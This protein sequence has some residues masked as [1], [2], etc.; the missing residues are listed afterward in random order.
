MHKLY[1]AG[2][3]VALWALALMVLENRRQRRELLNWQKAQRA[4]LEYERAM[5]EDLASFDQFLR[6]QQPASVLSE[7]EQAQFARRRAFAD[8]S[9]AFTQSDYEEWKRQNS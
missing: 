3:L 5:A 1:R 7:Q 6:E 9:S 4:A 8:L 2:F